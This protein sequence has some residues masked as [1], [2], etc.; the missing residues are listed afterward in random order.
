MPLRLLQK[1]FSSDSFEKI[2]F[3]G[4]LVL[5]WIY[6]EDSTTQ[7]DAAEAQ[8]SSIMVNRDFATEFN[9]LS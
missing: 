2:S 3:S 4:D 7:G 5:R 6:Q 1:S 9:P 8:G